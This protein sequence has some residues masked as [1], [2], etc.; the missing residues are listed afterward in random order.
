MAVWWVTRVSSRI[1]RFPIRAVS[2]PRLIKVLLHTNLETVHNP[3]PVEG[4]D[5]WLSVSRFRAVAGSPSLCPCGVSLTY[6][7]SYSN[8]RSPGIS[9]P[10][11][12]FLIVLSCGSRRG[13]DWVEG[14][15]FGG[16]ESVSD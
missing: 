15:R 14:L 9:Q 11:Q 13:T 1:Q 3:F 10:A 16:L 5:L 12:A 2:E 7:K 8:P 6:M 4:M